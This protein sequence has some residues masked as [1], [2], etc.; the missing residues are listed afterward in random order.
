MHSHCITSGDECV[1]WKGRELVNILLEFP[2]TLQLRM[3]VSRNWAG[4][5]HP[6]SSYGV[7]RVLI[8][9]TILAIQNISLTSYKYKNTKKLSLNNKKYILDKIILSFITL[10]LAPFP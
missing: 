1:R 2:R 7:Q 9:R 4:A 8:W 10:Q 6:A 3:G 5:G